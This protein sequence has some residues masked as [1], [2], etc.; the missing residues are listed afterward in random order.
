L[1]GYSDAERQNLSD[2]TCTGLQLANFWQ[3]VTVDWGKGRVY[4]PL[5]LLERHGSSIEDIRLRRMTNGFRAAMREAVDVAREFFLNG[6]PL[7]RMVDR[8][9]AL[10]L[11]LFSRG[12]LRVLDKIARRDYDVLSSRPAISRIERAGLLLGSLLRVARWKAA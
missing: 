3:D 5:S 8:R 2:A 6:L 10:D 9:L 4:L 7:V 11:D 12:G 1:C